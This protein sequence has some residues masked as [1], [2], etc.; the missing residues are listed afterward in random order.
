[1]P[2]MI[3]PRPSASPTSEKGNE[4]TDLLEI[5]AFLKRETTTGT[6][7]RKYKIRTKWKMSKLPFEKRPPRAKTFS[8]A[9]RVVVHL[10]DEATSVGSGR[11]NV[12]AKI[13]RKWVY[14]C[15]GMGNRGRLTVSDFQR[16]T[17]GRR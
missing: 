9:Q 2:K 8:G 11:R 6:A 15:D 1:M 14:I 12:W 5:P 13:G 3:I 10:Q 4:M 17:N 7:R 16:A